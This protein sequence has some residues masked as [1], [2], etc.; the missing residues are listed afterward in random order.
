MSAPPDAPLGD[1]PPQTQTQSPGGV[2]G[3][4]IGPYRILERLGEGGMG[5]VWLAEQT[6]P[7]RRQVALK[8]IK[9]GMDTAQ[10]VARFEAERQALALMD[11]PAIAKV[12]DAGA[13]DLGRPY[14]VMEKVRGESLTAYCDRER[15][16]IPQR[17]ELFLHV[18]EGVQHAHQKGIIHRDLKPSNILVTVQDD[19]VVP[20]IIDFGV[21]K[22]ISQPLTEHT[23]YTS[24]AGFVGTPEYMSPEQAEAGGIDIDTR[25][26]VY[27]LGVILYELLTGVLPFDRHTLKDKSIAEIRRTIRESDPLRPSTRIT[28]LAAASTDVA[29]IRG[30]EPSRLRSLLRGDLD[31]IT[32]KALEKDRTRRYGSAS[33]FAADISRHLANQPVLAGPPSA[34]Y[35][36]RKFVQRHRFGVATGAILAVLLLSFAIVMA[37]Q[38]GRIAR[39]RDRANS[40]AEAARQVAD[41]LV[42]L[43]KV[44]DPSEARGNAL[45]AREI[46]D[47]G[48]RRI[49]QELAA[50]PELR[51]RLQ[52]T[53][54]AVYTSLGLYPQAQVQLETAAATQ[55]AL[56]SQDHVDALTTLDRLADNYWYQGRL[57]DAEQLYQAL[58]ERRRR[59]LGEEHPD[60]LRASYDLASTYILQKRWNDAEGLA[61]RTLNIQRRVL[62][63]L[64]PDTLSSM[65]N[66]QAMY[67]QQRRYSDA[68]PIAR[69]VLQARRSIFGTGHPATLIA[70]HNLATILHYLAR[71]DEAE[72][73]YLDTIDGKRRVL[74]KAHPDTANSEEMLSSMYQTQGRLNESEPLALSAYQAFHDSFGLEHE[75]TQRVAR[76]IV[77]LYEARGQ[78]AT[79]EEWRARLSKPRQ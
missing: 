5:E 2:S 65:S 10:V 54:G 35:R 22:A 41:F 4:T 75:R 26:D 1:D 77:E 47:A 9:A 12:F 48:A 39:E 58:V 42:G 70:G 38:A 31:W 16:T 62:G 18:C 78:P 33:D 74:G 53:I 28:Q 67:F 45:T 46:L 56:L 69:E 72:R 17:L 52:A 64:H 32:M 21:A 30:A 43:F 61:V 34:V 63:A 15:L 27:A 50:Q 49:D 60:T 71:Y 73:L 13:T 59:V 7:V 79:A 3:G 44:S 55:R 25:T 66:L 51:A 76:K 8:V 14:F 19:R 24:V 68:E 36:S 6:R 11:H 23:L 29:R 57:E 20:K 40:E 37:V